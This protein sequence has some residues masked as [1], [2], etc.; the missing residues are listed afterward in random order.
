M[1]RRWG[2]NGD[3]EG[4]DIEEERGEGGGKRENVGT[5]AKLDRI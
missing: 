1:G 5:D 4:S 2:R 3:V